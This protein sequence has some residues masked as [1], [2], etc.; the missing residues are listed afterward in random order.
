MPNSH[1]GHKHGGEVTCTKCNSEFKEEEALKFPGKVYVHKGKVMCE[2]CLIEMGVMPDTA[3][4][5]SVYI[6][7]QTDLGR[8]NGI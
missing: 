1:K 4:P 7:A 8:S 3:D 5:Y 6:H 2:D